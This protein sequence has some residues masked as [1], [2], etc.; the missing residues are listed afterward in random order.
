MW[1]VWTQRAASG[2]W[3][4]SESDRSMPAAS[5]PSVGTAQAAASAAT[6]AS[7]R[8]FATDDEGGAGGAGARPIGRRATIERATRPPPTPA[9]TRATISTGSVKRP[10]TPT[11]SETTMSVAIA[12][13]ISA[14][15][16]GAPLHPGRIAARTETAPNASAARTIPSSRTPTR[17]DPPSST[18]SL[19]GATVKASALT[20]DSPALVAREPLHEVGVLAG[21]DHPQPAGRRFCGVGPL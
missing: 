10:T 9:I 17:Y 21:A 11:S 5:V 2:M 15:R 4:Q 19:P 8:S 7:A 6:T 20:R 18:R 13:T 12:T 3:Y 1:L 16:A 14:R